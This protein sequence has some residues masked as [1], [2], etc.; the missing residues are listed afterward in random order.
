MPIHWLVMVTKSVDHLAVVFKVKVHSNQVP[1]H[2]LKPGANHQPKRK[3]PLC[4]ERPYPNIARNVLGLTKKLVQN[5]RRALSKTDPHHRKRCPKCLNCIT[6]LKVRYEPGLVV[7]GRSRRRR[8]ENRQYKPSTESDQKYPL[9]CTTLLL[10]YHP[11]THETED[12]WFIRT[13]AKMT[14]ICVFKSMD[15]SQVSYS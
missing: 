12:Q 13:T 4:K 15:N 11:S 1:P 5:W 10:K 14:E 3:P 2:T 6:S 9:K 8:R 7:V